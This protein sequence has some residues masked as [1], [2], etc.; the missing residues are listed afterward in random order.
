M[1]QEDLHNKLLV[2][3]R[4]SISVTNALYS[5]LLGIVRNYVE[6]LFPKGFFNDV[7]IRNSAFAVTS[8]KN[9]DDDDRM[10]ISRPSLAMQMNYDIQPGSTNGDAYL[11]NNRMVRRAAHDFKHMY[12]KI[13]NDTLDNIY[14]SSMPERNKNV[15]DIA[16]YLNS[17][18]QAINTFG[19]LRAELGVE[20]P[21][22]INKRVIEIPMPSSLMGSIAAAKKY[23]V[24]VP[25]ELQAFAEYMESSSE[26]TITYKVHKSSGRYMFFYKYP[27]NILIKM[28]NL[29]VPDKEVENKSQLKG[30]TRFTLEVEYVN[31]N[32]F[33]A[34]TYGEMPPAPEG[35]MIMENNGVGAVINWTYQLPLREQLEDGRRLA[36][37]IDIITDVNSANLDLTPLTPAISPPMRKY[38]EHLTALDPTLALLKDSFTVKI[39]MDGNFVDEADFEV[40]WKNENIILFQ[41]RRN[42]AYRV[43]L[44]TDMKKYNDFYFEKYDNRIRK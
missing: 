20:R 24:L 18:F 27:C 16:L 29:D 12:T 42:F 10:V 37:K 38:V 30:I 7:F 25:T 44:Y 17:E 21:F 43:V 22:F 34:E 40:D 41:P 1:N 26:G 5:S 31:Y 39:L 13:I 2:S 9:L 8:R 35:S 32:G 33:I 23:N 36:G 4:Y 6:E 19:Y 15:F 28:T 14:I 3:S 11:F